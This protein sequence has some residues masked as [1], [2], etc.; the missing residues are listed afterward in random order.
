MRVRV[1][2]VLLALAEEE[3]PAELAHELRGAGLDALAASPGCPP[4]LLGI[5]VLVVGAR[6]HPWCPAW[7]AGAERRHP[8]LQVVVASDDAGLPAAVRALREGASDLLAC[9]LVPAQLHDAVLRALARRDA[10]ASDEHTPEQARWVEM[11]RLAGGLAHELSNPLAIILSALTGLEDA[12]ETVALAVPSTASAARDSLELARETTGEALVGAKRLRLL[13]R[14]LRAIFRS[15]PAAVSSTDVA[16]A[17]ATALRVGRAELASHAQVVV[18]V[19]AGVTAVASPGSLAEAILN[20]LRRA[21][22]A[23]EASGRRRGVVRVGARQHGD[24]VLIDIEDDAA[25]VAD[26][27]LRYLAAWLPAGLAPGR[28]AHALLA[29]HDLVVRQGGALSAHPAASEGTVIRIALPAISATHPD[30]HTP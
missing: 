8:G 11:G 23:I 2:S 29:A 17:V 13:A 21:A 24:E 18:E 28:G 30:A 22:Q 20:V 5:D 19:P 26:P 4:D 16:E 25:V 1:G 12:L 6:V 3:N 9:P 15:D 27:A 10:S 7:L 14:D